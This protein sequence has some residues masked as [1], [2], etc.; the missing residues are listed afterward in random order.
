MSPAKDGDAIAA[1]EVVRDAFGS[2]SD[3][4]YHEKILPRMDSMKFMKGVLASLLEDPHWNEY[5]Q[6]WIVDFSGKYPWVASV[7]FI[8]CPTGGGG[9]ITNT[10]QPTYDALLRLEDRIAIQAATVRE[11]KEQIDQ[12]T[13]YQ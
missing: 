8:A 1:L 7:A 3:V 11:T 10:R 6:N 4:Q 2:D 5:A 12:E 9:K 13:Q